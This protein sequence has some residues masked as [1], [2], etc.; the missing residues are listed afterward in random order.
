MHLYV[1]IIVP[2]LNEQGQ[3]HTT[4]A[5]VL[6]A[7]GDELIV[8]D[9]GVLTAQW[10]WRGSLPPVCFLPPQVGRAR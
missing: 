7:A 6:L 2:T 4:L 5:H 9:G 10:R 1:S 8:V 3:L